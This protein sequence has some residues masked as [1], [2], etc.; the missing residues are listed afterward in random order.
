MRKLIS[1]TLLCFIIITTSFCQTDKKEIGNL[2]AEGIPEIPQALMERMNQYQNIRSASLSSWNPDGSGMLIST[3][4]AETPQLHFIDHPGG[5]RRQITF[6]KEPITS[7]SYCPDTNYKG[8]M[9]TK[10]LGGNEFAQLFWFDTNTGKYEM[11]SDGGRSQNSL[12][13]WSNKGNQF[14]MVSTR[15]NSKDY[16]LYLADMKSPKDAKLILQQGGSWAPIDWAP[17]DKHVLVLNYISA[18]KSFLYIL[19]VET[20]KLEQINP[21]AEDISFGG[22]LW[23]GDGKGLYMISDQGSEFQT[24]KYYDITTKKSTDISSSIHWDIDDITA[25]KDRSKIVFTT[26]ENG[27]SK[28]YNLDPVTKKFTPS[29]SAIPIGIISNVQFTPDGTAL[30]L[31][32][33]TSQSPGDIYS[34]NLKDNKLTRWTYSEVGGL[35]NSSFTD[36]TLV[37]YETFDKVDGKVRKIPAFYYKGKNT[38]GKMPVVISIHGGPEGQFQP[39][40]SSFNSFMTN[41]LGIAVIA[42]NVRGSSG[43]GKTYLKL[44]NG[45]LREESVKD[46]GALLDWIAKQPELDASRIAVYGGSYGGY[47][48]L[49]SVFNYNAKIK[50]GIDVVGISNF[51]TFLKN[52]EDYRKDLRRVEYGDERDAKMNEYLTKIS[53]ANNVDKITKPLLIIQ[54]QNDP[55][56][57]FTESEQMKQKL[58]DKGNTVWYLLGKDEGHGFRKKNNVDYMQ[59]SIVLFLQQNL[60]N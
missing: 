48:V 56:V 47:M 16:D 60:M 39:F 30:G 2:V 6:F 31:V 42:P 3:R 24:L 18:N 45:F 7:G 11:I 51:V 26:N 23:S 9:F 38:S 44:D 5:A 1:S 52:T 14:L 50:C 4:F 8:F 17:D 32:I 27:I 41:E 22:A 40:F 19:D 53:P 20:S 49:S 57:P 25:T 36:P 15:R 54:G 21:S 12:P 58:R 34:I 29:I 28:L 13:T 46:I 35:N 10:D 43:Y 33:N 59:W 37:E 55:R